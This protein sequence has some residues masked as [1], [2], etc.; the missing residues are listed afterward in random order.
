VAW[1]A[2]AIALMV[3][4]ASVPWSGARG[5][6]ASP[7][8]AQAESS[9]GWRPEAASGWLRAQQDPSGGFPGPTGE[10]DPSATIDAVLALHA[11]RGSDAEAAPALAAAIAYLEAEGV[12]YARAG[13]G[14]AARLAMAAITG[15]RDPRAFGGVDLL[16]MLHAPPTT[17]IQFPIADIYG[18]ELDD[19][20]LALMA[21]PAAGEPVRDDALDP[22]RKRQGDDGGWAPDGSTE[23]GAADTRTT[24]LV[25][26]GLAANGHGADP[27]VEK[28]LGFLRGMSARDGAGYA[29]GPGDLSIADASSTALV[30][31][32]LV[33]AGQDP[34]ATEWGDAPMALAAFQLPDGGFR[35]TVDDEEPDL[36]ATAKAIPALAGVPLPV[37]IA[38]GSGAP[39]GNGCVSL[40]PAA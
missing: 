7:N 10:V 22:L 1:T 12:S 26:Q 39:E 17:S 6:E 15:G 35:A 19:H 29:A 38:C 36:L 24:A 20:A 2:L 27:M 40:A 18:D 37:A 13:A 21:L 30:L 9:E 11:A 32:A 34:A 23:P 16:T 5:L 14:Q 31:Q 28:A 3:C 25:V 33:A 4:A 8:I